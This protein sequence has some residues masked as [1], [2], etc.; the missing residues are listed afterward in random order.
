M[1]VKKDDLFITATPRFLEEVALIPNFNVFKGQTVKRNSQLHYS[2]KKCAL[3]QMPLNPYSL[4]TCF[5]CA[6]C[7]ADSCFASSTS[8]RHSVPRCCP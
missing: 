1:Q 3:L 7:G 4:T 2:Q 5:G 8:R 6:W